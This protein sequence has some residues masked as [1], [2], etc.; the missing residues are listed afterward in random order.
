MKEFIKLALFTKEF[1]GYEIIISF[2]LGYLVTYMVI[3]EF[4]II[5]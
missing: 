1:K 3:V 2:V 4:G 5:V